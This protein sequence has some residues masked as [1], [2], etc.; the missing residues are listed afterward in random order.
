MDH[1][2]ESQN[3]TWRFQLFFLWKFAPIKALKCDVEEN[4]NTHRF[5]E[6]HDT[7][8]D[9]APGQ[10]YS[11][12]HNDGYFY[13]YD[14]AEYYYEDHTCIYSISTVCD[15]NFVDYFGDNCDDY[16][17]RCRG[18]MSSR[19]GRYLDFGVMTDVGFM[20][21]LNCPQCGCDENGPLRPDFATLPL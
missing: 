2:F 15:S 14:I 11:Y 6:I 3:Q 9:C 12:V 8:K 21:A 18:E 16:A 5:C 1:Y 19:I 7:W 17:S 4:P 20:T 13:N 10:C